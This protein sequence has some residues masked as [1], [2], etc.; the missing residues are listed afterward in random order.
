[1]RF[2]QLAV[3][4][5][6]DPRPTDNS[7]NQH[8]RSEDEDEFRKR[9]RVRVF[10]TAAVKEQE[11]KL[12][13]HRAQFAASSGDAVAKTAIAG[14]E[15]LGGNDKG[16]GIGSE[17]EAELNQCVEDDEDPVCGCVEEEVEEDG[18]DEKG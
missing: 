4:H 7:T 14:G 11:S 8:K 6:W 15:Y 2:L 13:E 3:L 17:G 18:E 10:D 16:Q 1:M 12:D 9:H 5:A